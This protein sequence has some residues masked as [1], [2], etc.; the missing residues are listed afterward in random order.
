VGHAVRRGSATVQV[1]TYRAVRLSLP[2]AHG[3]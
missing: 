2:A 3:G 1:G